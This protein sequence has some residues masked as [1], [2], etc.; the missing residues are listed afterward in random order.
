MLVLALRNVPRIKFEIRVIV[1]TN[2]VIVSLTVK[3]M[4]FYI[5]I[6]LAI[7]EKYQKFK[8]ISDD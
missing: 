2:E 7:S 6:I 5:C 4:S 8:N 1:G 3:M